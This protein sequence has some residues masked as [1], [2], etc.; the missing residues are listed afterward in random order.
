MIFDRNDYNKVVNHNVERGVVYDVG[1][2]VIN[3]Y[4][5]AL[6]QRL[7]IQCRQ[8]EITIQKLDLVIDG[9]TDLVIGHSCCKKKKEF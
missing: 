3:H 4:L 6:R 7:D 9:V 5:C 8:N 2:Q 1:P